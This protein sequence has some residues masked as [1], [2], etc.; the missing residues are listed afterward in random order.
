M[1]VPGFR[2]PGGTSR[3]PVD[4]PRAAGGFGLLFPVDQKIQACVV[5]IVIVQMLEVDMKLGRRTDLRQR[6]CQPRESKER[7]RPVDLQLAEV[8]TITPVPGRKPRRPQ[9]MLLAP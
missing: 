7:R 1:N 9:T 4:D 3:I 2:F 5:N 8:L 6:V